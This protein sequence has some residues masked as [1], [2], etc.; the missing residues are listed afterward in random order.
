MGLCRH[1][2]HIISRYHSVFVLSLMALTVPNE[3]Q[4]LFD[5]RAQTDILLKVSEEDGTKGIAMGLHETNQLPKH[6]SSHVLVGWAV[7]EQ[8]DQH[9]E[10]VEYNQG[11]NRDVLSL[12]DD[13][14]SP[15]RHFGNLRLYMQQYTRLHSVFA[16][17]MEE[18][19][20]QLLPKYHL[21]TSNVS[22]SR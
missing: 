18:K 3:V 13:K 12:Q 11:R 2:T 7:Q 1:D 5:D 14:P 4:C 10:D 20:K 16:G 21:H 17:K 22:V 19:R 8:S 15:F 6:N 9:Q